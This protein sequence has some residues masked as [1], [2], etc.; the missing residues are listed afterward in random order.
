[1]RNQ[2]IGDPCENIVFFTGAQSGKKKKKK[3]KK[4]NNNRKVPLEK[5]PLV[6]YLISFL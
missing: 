5:S 6:L 1:M 2:K 4:K 3:K